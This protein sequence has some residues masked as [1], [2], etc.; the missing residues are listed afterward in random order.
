MD[1][2]HFKQN[3]LGLSGNV[4]LQASSNSGNTDSRN[5]SFSNQLQWNSE[6]HINLLVLG[7]EYGE[8]NDE[9][10]RNKSFVHGRHVWHYSE[11]F[12]VEFFVQAEENE[13]TRLSYRGLM[14]TGIRVPFA[15]SENH[16]AYL[17]LG[18]FQEVEKITPPQG[19]NNEEVNRHN[20]WNV[21][22]M[23]RYKLAD[24]VKFSNTLYWQPRMDDS[25]DRR[26]LFVSILDVMTT[27][28]FSFQFSVE[29]VFDSK[30]PDGVEKT[31]TQVKTGIAYSF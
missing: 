30:P 25:S 23:S 4:R 21:Y 22:L 28:Q 31:D 14:G 9:R 8:V 18:G 17:G 7:Y 27:R 15:E 12:D 2:V 1:S 3:Q 26:A 11:S 29:S 24:R 6:Q 19:S 16:L 20:R 13:F 10:N 5:I